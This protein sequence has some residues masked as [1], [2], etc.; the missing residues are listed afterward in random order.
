MSSLQFIVHP[1]PGTDDQ[2]NDR[3]DRLRCP[4]MLPVVFDR[5]CRPSVLLNAFVKKLVG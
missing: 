4:E 2:L 1:A 5:T 3:Y